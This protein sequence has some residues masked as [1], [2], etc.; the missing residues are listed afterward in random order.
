MDSLVTEL[1]HLCD[2]QPFHTGWYLKDLHT[3]NEANRHGDLVGPSASTRKVSILMTALKEIH[4]GR[5]S[6][7]QP[8]TP[9]AKYFINN[10]GCFRYFQTGFTLPLVDHLVMMIIVSDNVS[11]GVITELV[12]LDK[13]NAFCQAIGMANTTHR[14]QIPSAGLTWDHAPDATN[15]TTPNDVGHLLNMMVDGAR[16]EAAA[17]KLG[18]TPALCQKAI[19]I[20]ELAAIN[21]SPAIPDAARRQGRPQD[22]SRSTQLQ[23]CRHHLP[24]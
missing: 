4:E 20:H 15:A 17:A 1:N 23:R 14:D 10:S 12:G 16:D 8:V 11:T 5:L 13:I 7:E 9:D 2:S 19:E 24:R 6:F 18:V 3:G 22:R 21:Q